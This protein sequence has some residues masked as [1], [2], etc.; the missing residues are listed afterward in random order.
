VANS[1]GSAQLLGDHNL[2]VG[3]GDR[4]YFSE[5]TP[6][7]R[8]VLGGSFMRPIQSYRAYRA[9]WTGHPPWSPGIAVRRTAAANRFNVYAS[10]NGATQ[11]RRWRVLAGPT[12]TGPF[13][14]LKTVLWSSFETRIPVSTGDAYFKVQALGRKRKL[15]PHGTSGLARAQ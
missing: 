6:A 12:R 3:W 13:H 11:V 9:Q 1:E 7:G 15:L 2:F 5:Y 8:E 10:W 4:P 14:P